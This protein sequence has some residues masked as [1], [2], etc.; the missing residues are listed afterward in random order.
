[1]DPRASAIVSGVSFL[2][3]SAGAIAYVSVLE[4]ALHRY[5]LS[6]LFERIAETD[7]DRRDRFAAL[8]R[9]D[10]EFIQV[11][12]IARVIM[13]VLHLCGWVLVIGQDLTE[14][15]VKSLIL[16]AALSVAT[17]MVFAIV[18]PP[19]VIRGRFESVLLSQL[20]TFS[21]LALLFKP[22]TMVSRL[23]RRMGAQMEGVIAKETP[24]ESFKE[25]LADSLEEG[26]REGVLDESERRMIHSVVELAHT[27][28]SKAM[29]PRMEMSCSDIAGGLDAALKVAAD[30]GHSRVPI[31]EGS[32]EK[33]IGVLHTRDVLVRWSE[34]KAK[35]ALDLRGLLRTARY[36]PESK[37]LNEL[38]DEMRKERLS[39]AILLDEHGGTAGLITLE[40][41]VE[42]IVGDIRDEFDREEARRHSSKIKPF[43]G[44]EAEADGDVDLDELNRVLE[45][46]LP[47]GSEYNSLG[48]YIQNQMG[49]IPA[50]GESVTAESLRLTVVD[51]DARRIKR[52]K[53]SRVQEANT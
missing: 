27:P 10:K 36:W 49:R 50:I 41:I 42:R 17:L 30:D 20:P 45:L 35:G 9:R 3:V 18:V 40:D 16:S 31:Y 24:E 4:D 11:C 1:M 52:V 29:I 44:G 47:E 6:H 51:A 19:L 21:I 22:I 37:P 32:R 43:A 48:G 38:L 53:L 2:A 23:F 13:F 7:R 14:F 25:E 33:I 26:A 28:A 34:L 5:N 39:I 12:G 46:N 15:G 8:T